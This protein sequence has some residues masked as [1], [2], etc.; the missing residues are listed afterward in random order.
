M[1]QQS[2]VVGKS[3]SELDAALSFAHRANIE[4]YT[5][6]LG[7]YLTGTERDFVQRRLAEEQAAL[8]PMLLAEQ[9]P[10]ENNNGPNLRTISGVVY[11]KAKKS[12]WCAG[13]G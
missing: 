4:R 7:T 11:A 6:I 10:Q 1:P 3:K 13:S 9:P 5:K 12:F 2:H 8:E